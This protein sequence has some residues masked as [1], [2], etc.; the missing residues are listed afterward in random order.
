M[1]APMR[2]FAMPRK[3]RGRPMRG[4]TKLSSLAALALAALAA[5]VCMGQAPVPAPAPSITM[6]WLA[7]VSVDRAKVSGGATVRCTVTLLRP[8]VKPIVVG[9]T[10]SKTVTQFPIDPKNPLA[11]PPT[12]KLQVTDV[13]ATLTV[14]S[15]SSSATFEIRTRSP[16]GAYGVPLGMSC[17]VTYGI[18]VIYGG[19]RREAG[20]AVSNEPCV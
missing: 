20:F 5:P 19:E 14:P 4:L 16:T 8:A 6:A 3:E 18:T 10:V 17:P 9:V 11:L 2:S 1:S 12:H 15:G 13:P 7:S